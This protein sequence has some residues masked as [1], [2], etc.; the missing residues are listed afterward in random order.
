MLFNILPCQGE[1]NNDRCRKSRSGHPMGT[2]F[3]FRIGRLPF[4]PR[5]KLLGR[6]VL[7]GASLRPRDLSPLWSPDKL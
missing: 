1:Y 2:R 5:S 7:S 4:A 6:E 3:C